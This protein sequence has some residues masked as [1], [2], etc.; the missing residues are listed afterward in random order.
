MKLCL[1]CEA[2]FASVGWR[3]PQCGY[4]PELH[5]GFPSFAPALASSNDGMPAGSHHRLQQIQDDSFWF[6]ARNLLIQDLVRR[7]FPKAQ[8]VLEIGCGSGFVL[9]GLRTVLPAA[10]L[11][12]AEAYTSGLAYAARRVTAPSE[13]LQMDARALP[14]R[15]QFDLIGA[16]DVLE[17]IDEEDEPVAA[18]AQALKQSGGLLITVPQHRWLW[19]RV[20]EISCHRRRYE[21]GQLARLLRLHGFDV[22][23]ETSFVTLLLPLMLAHRAGPG[24]RA[25]YKPERE[26]AL[27]VAVQ[28]VFEATL[29]LERWLIARG[30]RLPVGGSQVI[31]ARKRA[32]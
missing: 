24:R 5:E 30:L 7:Y 22:V 28:R 29:D 13:F 14:Y 1:S 12:G 26:F 8:D 21:P 32:A 11:V 15:G 25:D 18:M 17:H 4:Q 2:E 9:A 3:C 19:S 10:R 23:R 31:V 20:D 16:F 6:R 27:P